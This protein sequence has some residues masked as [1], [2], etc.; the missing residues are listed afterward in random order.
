MILPRLMSHSFSEGRPQHVLR[1]WTCVFVLFSVLYIATMNT[2]IQGRDSGFFVTQ[3][4]QGTWRNP[5][6]LVSVHP[7]HYVLA[8]FLTTVGIM[9][10]YMAVT[11][12]SA[13]PAAATVAN[14]LVV[15]LSITRSCGAAALSAVSLGIAH[16][17]WQ[18]AT[19][20]EV[21]SIT[22]LILSTELLC[23]LEFARKYRFRWLVVAFFLNG[24]GCS[25]H[26]QSALSLPALLVVMT[27]AVWRQPSKSHC[28]A[29]GAAAWFLGSLPYS[30][31]IAL[32]MAGGAGVRETIRSAVVGA[33]GSSVL[34]VIP[35]KSMLLT[36]AF[37]PL[38]SFPNMT[39]P[40]SALGICRARRLGLSP[41][42]YAYLMLALAFHALFVVR[43]S[44]SDQYTF[45]LPT[46]TLLAVMA[47]IGWC[48]LEA[49]GSALFRSVIR[50]G[51]AV[52]LVTTPLV[53]VIFPP[54]ARRA[55]G[56]NS[57][58]KD[59]PYEDA[60]RR[61]LTP[62]SCIDRGVHLT[63]EKAFDLA[64]PRGLIF[65]EDAF[66]H[67]TGINY[68]RD[69]EER[70]GVTLM[71]W[72]GANSQ[73]WH[74]LLR[75]CDKAVRGNRTVVLVPAVRGVPAVS[76]PGVRWRPAEDLYV[77]ESGR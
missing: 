69:Q 34:N 66:Q 26:L 71:I 43:Y 47:G 75:I 64:G 11:L 42:I 59:R 10:P 2:S 53:Y 1:T 46:Y 8:R 52:L 9:P 31:L 45:F 22:T 39:L 44:V 72:P 40:L 41:T 74:E 29:L 60:Y 21:H 14:V 68:F 27:A 70:L 24:V 48:A 20:A 12:L 17:Y 50:V 57:I 33:W 13:L 6:G 62:W 61:L 15:V 28:L 35:T 4:Y 76:P 36:V 73:N 51:A 37:F 67:A 23:V 58:V 77:L 3:A 18:M 56:L 55:G 49:Y 38:Y 5:M 32:E 63:T 30:G 65:V 19:V 54:F 25:N 7:L 16:S